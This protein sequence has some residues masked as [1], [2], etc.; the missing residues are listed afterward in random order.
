MKMMFDIGDRISVRLTGEIIR[1]SADRGGDAYTVAF[2][3]TGSLT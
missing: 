1:Y 3:K 2:C